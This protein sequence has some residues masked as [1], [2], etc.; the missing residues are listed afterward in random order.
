MKNLKIVTVVAVIVAMQFVITAPPALAQQATVDNT[1][2]AAVA[3]TK[4]AAAVGDTKPVTWDNWVRAESD[5]M[6]KAYAGLGGF[7]KFHNIRKPT[8]ID[9]LVYLPAL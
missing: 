6:F 5:K 9:D 4:P 8:P 7:G 1:H 2:H 3:D